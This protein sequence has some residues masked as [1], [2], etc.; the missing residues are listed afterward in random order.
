VSVVLFLYIEQSARLLPL[1][2]PRV[3]SGFINTHHGCSSVLL[4]HLLPHIE[5]SLGRSSDLS[6]FHDIFSF[7]TPQ[8]W[9]LIRI[10]D[11]PNLHSSSNGL[12]DITLVG[13]TSRLSSLVPE[14]PINMD[15]L[16]LWD[17]ASEASHYYAVVM[18]DEG[19]YFFSPEII[20]LTCVK[21]HPNPLADL[22][23]VLPI[24]QTEGLPSPTTHL[25]DGNIVLDAFHEFR[26]SLESTTTP[27]LLPPI[28]P[29]S[30]L[31]HIYT[32]YGVSHLVT[33][34]HK[35]EKGSGVIAHFRS[36][37]ALT[38][39]LTALGFPAHFHSHHAADSANL[40]NHPDGFL[41]TAGMIFISLLWVP[42][43]HKSTL[44]KWHALQRTNAMH[45]G[46]KDAGMPVLNTV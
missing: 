1:I 10:L 12:R 26:S 29:C 23:F 19:V 16:R 17:P 45:Q 28:H 37:L 8:Q 11:I 32:S 30:T 20:L 27:S 36:A 43:T 15:L 2:A 39:L 9:S 40:P 24:L 42:A 46:S 41:F 22:N 25:I 33:F 7:S 4:E 21:V 18:D 5:R 13:D 35:P 44:E 38:E 3:P 31:E 34:A 6:T 14:S